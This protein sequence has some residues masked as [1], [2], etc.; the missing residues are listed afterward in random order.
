MKR[1]LAWATL[2]NVTKVADLALKL[3]G[4]VAVLAVLSF[5]KGRGDVYPVAECAA[6]PYKPVDLGFPADRL[7][8]TTAQAAV[9]IAALKIAERQNAVGLASGGESMRVACSE[10]LARVESLLKPNFSAQV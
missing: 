8:L 7:H 5:F 2:A 6:P 3:A 1:F 4:I 10:Y 9:P